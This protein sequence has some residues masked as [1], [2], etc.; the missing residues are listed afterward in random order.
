MSCDTVPRC[1][2]H[3]SLCSTDKEGKDVQE[4]P[5]RLD[6]GPLHPFAGL[7]ATELNLAGVALVGAMSP[8]VPKLPWTC[9]NFC[10][11]KEEIPSLCKTAWDKDKGL[12]VC[13]QKEPDFWPPCWGVGSGWE[14]RATVT[15]MRKTNIH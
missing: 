7:W 15:L 13:E 12:R 8:W 5:H 9:Q 3:E 2:E 14:G 1:R 11:T 6:W 4:R 10:R